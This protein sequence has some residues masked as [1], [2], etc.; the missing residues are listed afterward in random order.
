MNARAQ[1]S[2]ADYSNGCQL[3]NLVL[4]AFIHLVCVLLRHIKKQIKYKN[5][6]VN[7]QEKPY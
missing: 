4:S 2:K 3:S 5:N 7:G 6:M 1:L